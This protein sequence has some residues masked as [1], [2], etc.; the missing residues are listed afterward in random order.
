MWRTPVKSKVFQTLLERMIRFKIFMGILFSFGLTSKWLF[1]DTY[2]YDNVDFDRH[3]GKSLWP[4][5]LVLALVSL[6]TFTIRISALFMCQDL[7]KLVSH[8]VTVGQVWLTPAKKCS[9]E[10]NVSVFLLSSPAVFMTDLISIYS[11]HPP[12]GKLTTISCITNI[13]GLPTVTF[14]CKP[15]QLVKQDVIFY[16]S[17]ISLSFLFSCYY[18]MLT[19]RSPP[20]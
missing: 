1:S 11:T 4:L 3:M 19:D 12:K 6:F 5:G 13:P 17:W 8:I 10:K 7:P 20:Q 9:G 2:W 15:K 14:Y 18:L 16:S